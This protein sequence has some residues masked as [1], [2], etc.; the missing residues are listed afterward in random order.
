MQAFSTMPAW[1][2]PAA[3]LLALLVLGSLLDIV[4]KF[5]TKYFFVLL[6]GQCLFTATM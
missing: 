6:P 4:S 3:M 1:L 2:P 5:P